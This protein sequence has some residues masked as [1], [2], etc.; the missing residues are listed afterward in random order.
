[1]FKLLLKISY[2]Y[3]SGRETWDLETR[4][5]RWQK[6]TWETRDRRQETNVVGEKEMRERRLESRDERWGYDAT[7]S[8]TETRYKRPKTW[9]FQKWD[10]KTRWRERRGDIRDMR[11]QSRDMRIGMIDESM[12]QE[13]RESKYNRE[14]RDDRSEYETRNERK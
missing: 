4:D 8:E 11:W 10:I 2:R 5:K 1:M 7:D 9:R 3:F 6:K 13:A 12:R 14:T